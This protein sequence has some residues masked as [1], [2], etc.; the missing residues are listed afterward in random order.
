[1]PFRATFDCLWCGASHSTR[2]PDD[3]E[4]WAQLC[5]AC[6]GRAGENGF[7]RFRLR[8]A[9]EE[10]GRSRGPA[11]A[12][13]IA[14]LPDEWYLRRGRWALEPIAEATWAADL[15]AATLWV[16]RLPI[17]GRIVELDAGHGWWSTLLAT[18]GELWSFAASEPDL[19][20][21]RARLVAHRLRAH[22]HAGPPTLGSDRA[23]LVF[24]AFALGRAGGGSDASA[25]LDGIARLLAPGGALVV[26]DLAPA[27]PPMGVG[28][29]EGGIDRNAAAGG[30]PIQEPGP[31]DPDSLARLLA[32]GGW[33][34]AQVEL[35]G[36]SFVVATATRPTTLP[37]SDSEVRDSD[38][39]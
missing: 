16:D 38:G 3:V 6:V 29:D 25:T 5:P 15:D 28:R 31:V 39:S 14:S 32:V 1:M 34:D 17:H 37:G 13:R 2:S 33:R 35:I 11:A 19:E 30:S 24:A 12:S 18:K 27:A 10:R 20:R 36:R 23:D 26:I 22:I 7:L 9:L 8:A 21:V 4:G